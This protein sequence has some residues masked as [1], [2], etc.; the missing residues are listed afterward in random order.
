[1]PKV[2]QA[3]DRQGAKGLTYYQGFVSPD[4]KKVPLKGL[5]GNAWLREGDKNGSRMADMFDGTSNTLAVVEARN[6]V[7]WSKPED[8]PFGG[9]VPLLGEKGADRAPALRFDGS[10]L[11]FPTNLTAERFWPFVTINGG[12]VTEDPDDRRPIRGGR[13]VP[14]PDSPP[15]ATQPAPKGPPK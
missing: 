13:D 3:P 1:M 4:A 5:F 6:G 12:E 10:T 9:A 2:Y 8:L 7:V 14:P 15:T 11:L